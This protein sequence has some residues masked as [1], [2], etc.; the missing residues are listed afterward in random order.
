MP[1][2]RFIRPA[3][4]SQGRCAEI[5]PN[6]FFAEYKGDKHGYLAK[7]I[8]ET[9]EVKDVCLE[10]A[11]NVL[12]VDDFGIWG[13]TSEVDR[14]VIR[15][16]RKGINTIDLAEAEIDEVLDICDYLDDEVLPLVLLDLDNHEFDR[17]EAVEDAAL[18]A[19]I[20]QELR[21]A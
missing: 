11:M 16:Q 12:P 4:M 9:C 20:E 18:E 15:A 21:A 5:D 7:R 10:Y 13:G 14:K 17:N 19:K 3:W 8:C 2:L 6:L 1:K